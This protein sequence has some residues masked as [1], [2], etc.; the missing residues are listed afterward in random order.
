MPLAEEPATFTDH[1]P[2]PIELEPGGAH[3]GHLD[4]D[5]AAGLHRIDEEFLDAYQSEVSEYRSTAPAAV[6]RAG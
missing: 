1:H 2:P 6:V 3:L 5:L 4:F